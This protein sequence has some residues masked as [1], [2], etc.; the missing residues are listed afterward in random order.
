MICSIELFC[1]ETEHNTLSEYAAELK[2]LLDNPDELI[3]LQA[4][5]KLANLNIQESFMMLVDK[6]WRSNG[7]TKTRVAYALVFYPNSYSADVYMDIVNDSDDWMK[8]HAI[9]ALSKIKH[10]PSLAKITEIRNTTKRWFLY[11]ACE[12]ALRGL[13]NR[14]LSEKVQKALD[15]L[16]LAKRI[17]PEP[18]ELGTSVSA[19]LTN[20]D[21]IVADVLDI[22]FSIA[23]NGDREKLHAYNSIKVL[24]KANSIP[25]DYIER[26]LQDP[27]VYIRHKCLELI[28]ELDME[29]EFKDKTKIIRRYDRDLNRYSLYS[30]PPN[31]R[32]DNSF[33]SRTRMMEPK[34]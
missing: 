15:K 11:Y 24:E 19:I 1:R 14:P 12:K 22:Y 17:L 31:N 21:P 26:F 6:Y 8:W 34:R 23:Y 27:N 2:K 25:A 9:V 20:L 33:P 10:L 7:I 32:R 29:K 18:E 3:Q 13:E 4:I 5:R 30:L 16:R 28:E